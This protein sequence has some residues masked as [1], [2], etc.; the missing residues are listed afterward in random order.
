MEHHSDV[1]H[2]N[3]RNASKGFRSSGLG[4]PQEELKRDAWVDG[5]IFFSLQDTK[6]TLDMLQ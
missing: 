6:G 4:V 5:W 1:D 3:T 2:L